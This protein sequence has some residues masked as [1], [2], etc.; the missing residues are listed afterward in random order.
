MSEIA[1]MKLIPLII[2]LAVSSAQQ[3]INI[4][5]DLKSLDAALEMAQ[6]YDS[7]KAFYITLNLA[8]GGD[9]GGMKG[10][11]E[12]ALP[13]TMQIDYVRVFQKL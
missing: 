5:Q 8:W 2:I 3:G 6:E 11:D 1:F 12:A 4:Q 9:W 13:C 10:V 7:V